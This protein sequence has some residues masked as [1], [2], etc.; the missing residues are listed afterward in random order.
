M[1]HD[2]RPREQ[3]ASYATSLRIFAAMLV[4][5]ALFW[6]GVFEMVYG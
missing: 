4:L 1:K 3:K 6:L 2:L 5:G